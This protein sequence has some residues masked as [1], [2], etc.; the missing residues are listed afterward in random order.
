MVSKEP[1]AINATI[2]TARTAIVAK[3]APLRLTKL[4]DHSGLT[5]VTLPQL[6]IGSLQKLIRKFSGFIRAE[7]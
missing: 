1:V 2:D 5:G 3:K 4:A 7:L 6:R